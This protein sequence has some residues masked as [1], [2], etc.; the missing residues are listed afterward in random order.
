MS[1]L[2]EQTGWSK[3]DIT[4]KGLDKVATAMEAHGVAVETLDLRRFV[5]GHRLHLRMP[6]YSG[7]YRTYGG[8]M[9]HCLLEKSLEHYLSFAL[10]EPQ[11]GQ[12]AV[13]I[14]SCKSVVPEILRRVYGVQCYEQDLEYPAGV[15]GWK[16]GSSAAQIPL[17]D[18]SVDFMTLHCTFEHFEG[19]AD[20]GFV[21]ECARLLRPGGRVIILPL[22]L[23]ANH[24]N[25][26]GE[27]DPDR[28]TGIGFDRD[29]SHHCLIPEWQ[30][31]FG[32]HYSPSALI[33]RVLQPAAALGLNR[34]LLR[35]S[36]WDEIDPRLWL[37]WI[38]VLQKPTR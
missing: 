6:D 37:R 26:T 16:V 12:T 18:A 34:R 13:D 25:V 15:H 5:E 1:I 36:H 30:N 7:E 17:P 9:I 8:S 22:Y 24:C 27:I 21:Q 31:R 20:T 10:A 38:L 32:R 4:P 35:V 11:A 3:I 2:L 23:N 28:R 33:E 29:A 19:S 14:G